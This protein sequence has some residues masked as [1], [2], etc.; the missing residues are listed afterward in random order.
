MALKVKVT[1]TQNFITK[2]KIAS[3]QIVDFRNMGF[4]EFCEY[5]SQDS[6]VGAAD[7]AAVM[8]QMEKKLPLLLSLGAKVRMSPGGMTVK[9]T[10]SGSLSERDLQDK[11]QRR[12]DAGEDVDV[13]RPL[14]ASDLTMSD[15]KAGVAID[16]GKSFKSAFA[17]RVEFQ[18]VTDDKDNM[19]AE[20]T[21]SL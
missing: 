14:M 21:Q 8:M 15:L 13:Y 16:F 17:Q 1:V 19:C 3:A 18:R 11:L 9:A 12:K 6:T 4:E 10:V 20:A 2:R 5:L 7:V